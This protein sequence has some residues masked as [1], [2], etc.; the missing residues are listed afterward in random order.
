ML[1]S[2]V[3]GKDTKDKKYEKLVK[4]INEQHKEIE[5][6]RADKQRLEEQLEKERASNIE[7]A[8][9]V[10]KILDDALAKKTEIYKLYDN[11][12]ECQRQYT[13]TVEKLK[14]ITK[15]AKTEYQS[16]IDS[17]K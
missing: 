10:R 1:I 16:V 4:L 5:D 8:E 2:T 9:Q 14:Q 11:V 3:K 6:L 12:K 17:I 13:L 15:E 7:S